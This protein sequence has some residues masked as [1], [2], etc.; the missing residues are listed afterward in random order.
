MNKIVYSVLRIS[1]TIYQFHI[2]FGL[3][4]H[5]LSRPQT[6]QNH[7]NLKEIAKLGGN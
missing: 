4:R 2:Q 3:E 5:L 7:V 1:Q 6:C